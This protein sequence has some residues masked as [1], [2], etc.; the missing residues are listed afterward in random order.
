MEGMTA[1]TRCPTG[2]RSP[3]GSSSASMCRR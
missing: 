2:T 3:M 1:P